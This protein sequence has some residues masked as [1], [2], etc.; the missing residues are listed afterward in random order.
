MTAKA[1][2]LPFE[3]MYVNDYNDNSAEVGASA[4]E[5]LQCAE[6]SRLEVIIERPLLI[7]GF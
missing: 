4:D 5:G 7:A 3:P 2:H 6:T 1:T